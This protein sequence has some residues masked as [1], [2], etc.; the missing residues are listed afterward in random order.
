MTL[1]AQV[2]KRR[3][4]IT[5]TAVIFLRRSACNAGGSSELRQLSEQR[6]ELE[7][8]SIS[9]KHAFGSK[10]HTKMQAKLSFPLCS[11]QASHTRAQLDL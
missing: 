10:K 2:S 9:K 6:F 1:S 11:P 8:R 5:G 7:L 3:E 4:G